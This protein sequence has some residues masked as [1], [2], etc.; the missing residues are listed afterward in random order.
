VTIGLAVFIAS[1]ALGAVL[2]VISCRRTARDRGRADAAREGTVMA[3]SLAAYTGVCL[4]I[5]YSVGAQC[6]ALVA[7]AVPLLLGRKYLP[8]LDEMRGDH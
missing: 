2:A 1:D 8:S 6:L 5:G 3:L 7:G 4:W